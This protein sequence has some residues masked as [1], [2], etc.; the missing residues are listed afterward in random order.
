MQ[1]KM[2]YWMSPMLILNSLAKIIKMLEEDS[3]SESDFYISIK[4]KHKKIIVELN[5]VESLLVVNALATKKIAIRGSAW[6]SIGKNVEKPLVDR[7]CELSGVPMENID[8]KIFKKNKTKDYDREVD[9]KLIDKNGKKYRI[10]IKLMGKGNPKSADVIFARETNIFI[11]DTLSEQNKKQLENEKIKY[12][13]MK[14]NKNCVDDFKKILE[15]L[16]IPHN[17]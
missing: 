10:E 2:L 13:E 16:N 5:L 15:E 11:A 14:N 4:I 6:S 3:N 12:L 8:N 9:Y 7:L 17:I 1:K